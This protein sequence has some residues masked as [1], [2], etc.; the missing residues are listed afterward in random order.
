MS[1]FRRD[2]GV[3]RGFGIHCMIAGIE[4]SKIYYHKASNP[5][6]LVL[7]LRVEVYNA[8]LG[9]TLIIGQTSSSRTLPFHDW[10]SQPRSGT[11][12]ALGTDQ[13]DFAI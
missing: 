6:V 5:L 11:L 1:N 3:P 2:E 4:R 7:C 12:F 13:S 9:L 8:V 10:A